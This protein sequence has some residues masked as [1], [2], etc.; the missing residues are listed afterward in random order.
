MRKI[1]PLMLVALLFAASSLAQQVNLETPIAV[2]PNV[3]I[4]KLDNGIIYYIRKNQK[5]EKRV[6]LRLAVNAGSVLEEDNQQG[7]AHFTEHMA[8]N[9][10]KHFPKNEL[11]NFL[12]KTGVRF[13]A[14]INAYTGFD[15]TVYMVQIPTDQKGLLDDGFQIIE[16]WAHGQLMDGK[17]IDKERGVIVEEWRLGLGADDRMMKRYFPVIFKG[18]KYAD[19]LPIGKV[20]VLQNFQHEA[21]RSFYRD[22]YRPDLQAVV[23]V[24]DID[25][26]SAEAKIIQHFSQIQMPSAPKE[27]KEFDIPGNTEP[28]IA[29]ETDKEASENMFFLFYKHPGKP[30]VN[31]RDYRQKL[32]EE[33]YNGMLG[34]RLSELSQKP[35]C[36]FVFAS[37][38]YG[39]FLARS[40]EAYLSY[41]QC[42]ENRI[43]KALETVLRENERVRRHGFTQGEFDRQKEDMLSRYET[44]AKEFNKTESEVFAGQYVDHYL[45]KEPIPGAQ[46][47]LKYTKTLL[48]GITLEEVN[49]LAD[50]WITNDNLALVI[51]APEKEGV[52]VPTKEDVLSIIEKAK[53]EEIG[54]YVDTFIES[55]LVQNEPKGG[56]VVDS[57]ENAKLGFTEMTLGNG[58]KVVLKPTKFKNDEILISAFSLGGISQYDDKEIMSATYTDEIMNMSGIGEFDNI[59]L[60]KKLKGKVIEIRPVIDELK[61]GFSGKTTP[62]DMETLF[63]L[64]YLYFD[65]PRKDTTAYQAFVSQMQNQM[66]FMRSNPIMA[67]YDTLFKSAYPGYQRMIIFPTEA[68]IAKIS[69]DRSYEMYQDRFADASDFLF[70]F[71]G[72]FTIDSITPMVEKYLGS[73]PGKNRKETWKNRMPN[74]APGVNNVVFTKGEDPQ[75]MVALA[76]SDRFEWNDKNRMT[77]SFLREILN[78]KLVEVIREEL[79]GVYSPAVM[80]QFEQ[81]PEPNYDLIIFFGCNPKTTE[82]LTKAVFRIMKDIQK[83]GPQSVDLTKAREAMIRKRETDLEKNEFWLS[84]LE[85]AY[86]NGDDPLKINTYTERV[87]AITTE[88]VKQAAQKFFNLDHYVRVVLKPEPKK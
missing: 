62:K 23:V 61:E 30:S 40:N 11:I 25:I 43:D 86:F 85:N 53:Q 80:L 82:K 78:I 10:T 22:W 70:F 46:R 42:K 77:L 8:F 14:D 3:K 33:I 68:Q 88:D 16:D 26:D 18:S 76:M 84:Y 57:K 58:V 27:R 74:L 7:L 83:K 39:R 48:P 29:I 75:S 15:Q 81:Y 32:M 59:A 17:E 49:A 73:L 51:T 44:N 35:E 4:G 52:K 20:E 34:Q 87:N 21:I 45:E 64:I 2:D 5:P 28:L 24:G 50:K 72:N 19:R 66:K 9:G 79:S 1:Y 36:P 6:E 38:S 65:A 41:A 67:F 56:K 71:T 69:L 60:Q 13:G 12:Q 54:P 47:A 31:L 63:Q 37:T 55:P